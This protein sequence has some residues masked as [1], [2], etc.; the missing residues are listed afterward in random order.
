MKLFKYS[1]NKEKLTKLYQLPPDYKV[2]RIIE[3]YLGSG[4][5]SLNCGIEAPTLGYEINE[6]L[7][8][9][10]QWL[11]GVSESELLEL[12]KY[13]EELKSKE[14]KPDLKGRGLE[15]G[16]LT[17]LRVNVCSVVVG[18]LSSWKV[19]PQHKLPVSKTI[20][21]LPRLKDFEVVLGSGENF[22]DRCGD[23]VFIDPPYVDTSANYK[24]ANNKK[25]EI[26]YR[27]EN[28]KDLVARLSS[29]IIFTYGSNA[30]EVFPEYD[31]QLV[32]TIKVPNMRRGGTVDRHEYVC[33]INFPRP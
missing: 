11:K 12:N 32:K 22:S 20:E 13:L 5:F 8:A 29:P 3:P 19:Y 6:D 14:E 26:Q 28:T 27:P 25:I 4:A 31:W 16:P 7:Y 17:Y 9:M 24:S 15:L 23:L 33:Y 30:K 1:G 21:C 18:Q 10:W 2:K